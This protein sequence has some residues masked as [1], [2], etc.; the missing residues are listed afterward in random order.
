MR[1][2]KS[3]KPCRSLRN[4]YHFRISY[5]LCRKSVI[6]E[7]HGFRPIATR[8]LSEAARASS[9]TVVSAVVA[10]YDCPIAI[11]NLLLV[12][13]IFETEQSNDR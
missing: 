4:A 8:H 5:W 6:S 10:N 7:A 2:T 1:I 9:M 3:V 13:L 11:Y 12:S